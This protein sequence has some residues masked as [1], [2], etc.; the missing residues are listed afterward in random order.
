[1]DSS[2]AFSEYALTATEA[3]DELVKVMEEQEE[4]ISRLQARLLRAKAD[5]LAVKEERDVAKMMLSE[6]NEQMEDI[7]REL[8]AANVALDRLDEAD[9]KNN[10]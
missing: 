7:S 6:R 4:R 1:M 5:F 3:I 8:A 9:R 2:V 10:G